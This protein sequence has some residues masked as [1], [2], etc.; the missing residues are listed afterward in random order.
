MNHCPACPTLSGLSCP[1]RLTYRGHRTHVLS[2]P[3]G[4][5]PGQPD[6]PRT[7]TWASFDLAPPRYG[8]AAANHPRAASQ[9][10]EALEGA[11]RHLAR[12]GLT[13]RDVGEL[14]GIG[15]TAA[16]QLIRPQSQW[17]STR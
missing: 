13:E 16:A 7:A 17:G 1:V 15:T 14:L 3:G 11:A 5:H 12:Q 8:T 9:P 4:L 6:S 2:C 10:R